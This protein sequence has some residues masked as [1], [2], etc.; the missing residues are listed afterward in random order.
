MIIVQTLPG[1]ARVTVEDDGPGIPDEDLEKVFDPFFSTKAAGVG[2]GLTLVRNYV[3][4]FGGTVHC[5]NRESGGARVR[6]EMPLSGS[7]TTYRGLS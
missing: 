6:F 4:Q 1:A 7:L 5:E 2:L 3:T